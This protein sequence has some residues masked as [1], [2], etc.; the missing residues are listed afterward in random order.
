M[1]CGARG[2]ERR[3]TSTRLEFFAQTRVFHKREHDSRRKPKRAQGCLLVSIANTAL[4]RPSR[5]HPN[6]LWPRDPNQRYLF[7]QSD[8]RRFPTFD[9]SAAKPRLA[10]SAWEVRQ[11][12]GQ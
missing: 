4:V 8:R 9:G 1:Q 10:L 12:L 3:Y 11:Y 2:N 7:F 6:G 5:G